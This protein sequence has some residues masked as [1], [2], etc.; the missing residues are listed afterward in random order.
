MYEKS[1]PIPGIDPITQINRAN[2]L[3]HRRV[4]RR[5]YLPAHLGTQSGQPETQWTAGPIR[6]LREGE[7]GICLSLTLLR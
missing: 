1:V 7:I 5:L 6:G 4:I 3:F 2:L